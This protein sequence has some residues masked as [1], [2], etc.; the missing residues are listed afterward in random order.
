LDLA[1]YLNG[2]KESNFYFNFFTA[3]FAQDAE[4]AELNYFSFG[5]EKTPKDNLSALILLQLK[6]FE[7]NYQL[8]CM[9]EFFLLSGVS[10]ESNKNKFFAYFAPLPAIASRH[11]R[12]RLRLK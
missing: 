10:A 4:G 7:T 3:R 6:V 2:C 5:V 12:H 8:P 11:V 1:G 9:D